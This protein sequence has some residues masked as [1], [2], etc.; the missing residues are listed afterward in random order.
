[1]HRRQKI[2]AGVVAMLKAA[3]TPAGPRVYA[4][5]TMPLE[6]EFPALVV[7]VSGEEEGERAGVGFPD[8]RRELP[9][10]VA[11]VVEADD[12]EELDAR[13]DALAE[14]IEGLVLADLSQGGLA[15]DT[16]YQKTAFAAEGKGDS[17]RGAARVGFLITYMYP[18]TMGGTP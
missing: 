10:V 12:P 18:D 13:V 1:M 3:D 5:R 14:V 7:Y 11:G 17:N 8:Y 15:L 4:S 16:E 6:A 9:L 2:I